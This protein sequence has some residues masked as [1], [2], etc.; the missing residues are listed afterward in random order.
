MNIIL[1]QHGDLLLIWRW[2]WRGGL[3]ASLSFL[4]HVR[5]KNGSRL[6]K[7]VYSRHEGDERTCSRRVYRVVLDGAVRVHHVD[8][9]LRKTTIITSFKQTGGK[10]SQSLQPRVMSRRGERERPDTNQHLILVQVHPCLDWS[11]IDIPVSVRKTTT[12]PLFV[13]YVLNNS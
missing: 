3:Y 12:L 5:T 4:K 13:C 6:E 7:H 9:W 11:C 1:Q 10:I 2:R 8:R